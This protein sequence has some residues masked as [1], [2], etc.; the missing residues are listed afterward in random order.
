MKTLGDPRLAKVRD[1]ILSAMVKRQT[2]TLRQ[3]VRNRGE[4]VSYGR[5]Q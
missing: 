1:K 3:L 2:V 5:F 4:E